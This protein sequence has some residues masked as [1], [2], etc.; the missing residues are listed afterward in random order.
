MPIFPWMK[1]AEEEREAVRRNMYILLYPQGHKSLHQ[2]YILFSISPPFKKKVSQENATSISILYTR[3]HTILF[4]MGSFSKRK[5]WGFR[6]QKVG[7]RWR[8]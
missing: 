4:S 3:T 6:L 2:F 5:Y 8:R 7:L 1:K